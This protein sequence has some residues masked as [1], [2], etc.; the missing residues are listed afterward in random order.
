M[1]KTAKIITACATCAAAVG[2]CGY[3]ISLSQDD[4]D[5][6]F[7]NVEEIAPVTEA[8]TEQLP[9]NWDTELGYDYVES[10]DGMSEK[11]KLFLQQNK[12]YIGWISID[13]TQIDDPIVLDPGKIEP[14]TGYGDAAYEPNWYYLDHDLN[15]EYHR[16]GIVFMDYRNIFG[17]SEEQQSENI[18]LYGHNMANN[19]M[20]GPLRR[21]RQDYSFYD[22]SPFIDLSSNY[23]DYQYVIFGF[24]ITS[25]NWYTDFRYWDMQE[26]DTEE[27]F[28]NYVERIRSGAMVDTGV[29]VQYGDKLLT[30]S[31]CYADEDNSRFLVVARRLRD[32]EIPNDIT[33]IDRTEEYLE[34]LAAEEASRKAEEEASRADAEAEAA[35]NSEAEDESQED[36]TGDEE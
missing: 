7:S 31:T 1:N 24:M 13:N 10:P 8:P 30:L 27:D 34:K 17:A 19:T 23:K 21:Y 6:T 20:F 5:P 18:V 36:T 2:L 35:E 3:V 12:D 29:D 14:G 22:E 33:S 16:A 28:N 4:G 9:E 32:H 15:G 25:G 11:A 26:L